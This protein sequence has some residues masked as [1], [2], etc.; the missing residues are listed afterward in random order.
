MDS[1]AVFTQ[2]SHREAFMGLCINV[3]PLI[4][5]IIE[6]AKKSGVD[7]MV[8]LTVA[9]DGYISFDIHNSRWKMARLN[10]ESPAKI[11]YQY[12]EVVDVPEARAGEKAV[13]NHTTENVIEIAQAFS[14][15]AS[16]NYHLLDIDSEEWK[17]K[18][19]EWANEFEAGWAD[20]LARDYLDEVGDFAAEKINAYHRE[21][22]ED[23]RI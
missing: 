18:F 12:S 23:G 4:G 22:K 17:Q 1:K 14:R 11:E 3:L 13:F 2:E 20:D 7:G 9:T 6:N 10:G 15:M 21:A 16:E 19:V 5:E 8:G